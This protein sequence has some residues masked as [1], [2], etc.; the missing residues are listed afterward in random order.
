MSKYTTFLGIS[1]ND[2]KPTEELKQVEIVKNLVP[3][4]EEEGGIPSL[5]NLMMQTRGGAAP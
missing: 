4:Y 5:S 3:Q 1:K 2:S